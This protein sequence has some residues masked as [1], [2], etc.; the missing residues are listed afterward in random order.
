MAI[1]QA[2]QLTPAL[3]K[4]RQK[5]R[6]SLT[7]R[8]HDAARW[9]SPRRHLSVRVRVLSA[10]TKI[11]KGVEAKTAY[12]RTKDFYRATGHSWTRGLG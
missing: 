7:Q 1:I 4:T 12:E 3:R 6:S 11:G 8:W 2:E 10:F 9:L 5:P